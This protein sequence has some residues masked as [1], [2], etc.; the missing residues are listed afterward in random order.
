MKAKLILLF[1]FVVYSFAPILANN[2]KNDIRYHKKENTLKTAK[3][4]LKIG[5]YV[6]VMK[7]GK[8][9]ELKTESLA[10]ATIFIGLF[11]TDFCEDLNYQFQ[12]TP[13][14]RILALEKEIY[15][16]KMRI[17]KKGKYKRLKKSEL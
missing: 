10:E 17:T 5:Y 6:F 1:A 15:V 11:Y 2:A 13:Y 12:F 9:S 16:E 7:C 3:T 4:S 8:V 14:V